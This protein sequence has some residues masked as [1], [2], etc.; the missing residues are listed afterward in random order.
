MKFKLTHPKCPLAMTAFIIFHTVESATDPAI[1]VEQY[2]E[3]V[4][5]LLIFFERV[6]FKNSKTSIFHNSKFPGRENEPDH[7]KNWS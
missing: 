5:H 2:V 7:I 4:P 6:K 3:R 1:L